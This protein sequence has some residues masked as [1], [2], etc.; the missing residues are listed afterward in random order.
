MM[1]ILAFIAFALCI[2]TWILFRI[3]KLLSLLAKNAGVEP[4]YFENRYL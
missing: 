3:L 1:Y 2:N 4:F